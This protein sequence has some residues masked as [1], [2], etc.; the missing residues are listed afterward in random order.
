MKYL[1]ALA[2]VAYR[3]DELT[4]RQEHGAT[5]EERSLTWEDGRRLIFATLF[6]MT[7]IDRT[8]SALPSI[9]KVNHDD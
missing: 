2:N 6:A 4:Q 3:A 7:E 9:G 8:L 1:D 5:R